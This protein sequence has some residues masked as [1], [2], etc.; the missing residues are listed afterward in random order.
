MYCTFS[1]VLRLF[2]RTRLKRMH[3]EAL[4]ADR[5]VQARVRPEDGQGRRCI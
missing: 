3:S 5:G 2:Y 4:F 1:T